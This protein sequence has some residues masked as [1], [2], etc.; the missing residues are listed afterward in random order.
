MYLSEYLPKSEL[1]TEEHI[2]NTPRFPV[3]DIHCHYR[4]M[5]EKDGSFKDGMDPASCV[6]HLKKYGVERVVNLD[7]TWGVELD[8]LFSKIHPYEDRIIIFGSVDTA[9]IDE[10]NF[11]SY[12]RTTI[13]ESYRK[14][15]KGLKFFKKVSLSQKDA[16]GKYIAIDDERLKPIWETA[17]ELDIP[18]LIH[19]A[20][21]V[22]FFKPIDRYNE[23]YEELLAHPNWSYY[24][25][26]G[27]YTFEELMRM[28]ENL[29]AN[30]PD[31]TFI[32]AHVGSYSENLGQVAEWLDRFPN[33]NI[34]I[35]AR[36]AE[37]GRQPYAARKFFTRYQD[38][39]L[40]GVDG[41]P[42]EDIYPYYYRF[43]ETWDE[44]FDYTYDPI[45][46]N[47]RWKIHGIGL[48]DEILEKV[49]KKNAE[50]ILKI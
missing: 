8:A 13:R 19:I 45:P 30:N 12:V 34:D 4:T 27:M 15:I 6:E 32:I 44:Y 25:K 47:G 28:Q 9:R 26:P 2:V 48:E 43:L 41:R 33:M 50:R 11:G 5:F 14:G 18:V 38:R 22:A 21:P 20:D 29:L 3:I 36:L 23:R 31:T 42:L 35:A 49:Y 37:L 1:V 46:N 7:G 40:F 17:A 16:S 39:I 10:E 24:N